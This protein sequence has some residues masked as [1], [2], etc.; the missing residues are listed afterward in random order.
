MSDPTPEAQPTPPAAVVADEKRFTQAELEQAIK[1]R[2]DRAQRK[3]AA[4]AEKARQEAEAK[5]LAEQG[6]FK[7]L[8]EQ[9][10]ARIAELEQ[11]TEQGKQV[12]KDLERYQAAVAG[13]VAPKLEGLSEQLRKLVAGLDPL[14]QLEW[15]AA[16]E[17]QQQAARPGAPALAPTAPAANRDAPARPQGGWSLSDIYKR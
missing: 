17:P 2:L 13:I 5:A 6:E 10:Q 7:T 8:A 15:V 11:A 1:D 4:D 16:L 3:A 12:T 9:R 14:A